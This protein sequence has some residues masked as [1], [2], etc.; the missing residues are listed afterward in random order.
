MENLRG[1]ITEAVAFGSMKTAV[2]GTGIAA[3]GI[4]VGNPKLISIGGKV[5]L[6]SGI[7][8]STAIISLYL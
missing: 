8:G 4:A 7:I 5:V 6:G 2:V 3:V 1:K